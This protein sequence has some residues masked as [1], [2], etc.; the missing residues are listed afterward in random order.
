MAIL[1]RPIVTEKMTAVTEKSSQPRKKKDGSAPV[2]CKYGFY[3][4]RKANKI[5]IKKAV[6]DKFG[7]TVLDVNTL[8]RDGKVK[9]RYTKK[10]FIVGKTPSFKKAFVTLKDGDQIDFYSNIN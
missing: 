6:E 7:V 9:S 1:I 5:Q 2:N 8:N 4:D 10:G 3:V